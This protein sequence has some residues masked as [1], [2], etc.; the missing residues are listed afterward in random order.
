MTSPL[1]SCGAERNI[2]KV[3]ELKEI[4]VNCGRVKGELYFFL[5]IEKFL[6]KCCHMKRGSES[7]QAKNVGKV[8]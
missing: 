7:V 4:S 2:C 3:S 1:T 8:S 5:Y 6:T